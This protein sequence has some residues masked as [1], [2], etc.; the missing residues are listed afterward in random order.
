[1]KKIEKYESYDKKLFD[2]ESECVNYEN[3]KHLRNILEGFNHD[4]D[5]VLEFIIET[6]TD[7]FQEGFETGYYFGTEAEWGEECDEYMEEQLL[8][9][10]AKYD[11][12][13][14]YE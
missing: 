13:D 6:Q 11:M 4:M 5:K 3:R 7:Y 9:Q 10:F 2:T 14:D 12:E 1:M 8:K